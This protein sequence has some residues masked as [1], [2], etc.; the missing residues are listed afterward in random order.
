M[1]KS[2]LT[3]LLGSITSFTSK[4]SP[5]IMTGLAVVGV[6]ASVVSTYKSAPK[7]K[8]ILDHH[9]K[10][11]ERVDMQD[12]EK[13]RKITGQTVKELVPHIAPAAVMSG[14][15]IACI[16]GSHSV[17]N[18]R[19]A[20][21][22]A[23]YSMSEK[24]VKDLNAKMVETLG[25]NK[26]R[27]I[28]D[29]IVKDKVDKDPIDKSKIIM[30]PRTGEHLCK[31]LYSG[32]MFYSNAQAI[33]QAINRLSH[34]IRTEMYISL[35]DLYDELSNPNLPRIPLGDDVGW[36][37]DD[38]IDGDLPITITSVLT[39]NQEPCLCLDYDAQLRSDFRHLH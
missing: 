10:E 37:I 3:N 6:I 4:N 35:N 5:A 8:E 26:T 15:T 1:K 9:K 39:E 21:I 29:A 16:L 18:R 19:I 28:K 30:T 13:K 36:N 33:N 32:R 27:A 38:V 24:A 34:R 22:S 12:K 2:N 25:Q 7:C 11:M 20:A 17:S 23:A 31:D 14:A